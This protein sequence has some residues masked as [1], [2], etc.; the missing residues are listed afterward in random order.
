MSNF[1]IPIIFPGHGGI[2]DGEYV[3][4]PDKMYIFE[5]GTT[6]Y[7]GEVNRLICE[8]AT[9]FLDKAGVPYVYIDTQLDTPLEAKT[10]IA[11]RYNSAFGNCFLLDIHN[12]AGGGT[13]SEVF[14]SPGQTESDSI[15]EYIITQVKQETPKGWKIRKDPRDGDKDKEAKFYVLMQTYLPSVLLECGF[16][17]TKED[18]DYIMSSK[19]QKAF[20]K[21]IA[22][23]ILRLNNCKKV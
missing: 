6:I 10:K 3:T 2:I 1:K 19:G 22:N 21:A 11:E 9:K 15:A 12:N 17:D 20:G 18:A 7:E 8:Q 4:A 13:G 23:G 16:M 14:T 5:D